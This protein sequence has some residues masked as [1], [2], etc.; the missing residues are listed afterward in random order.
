ML[1]QQHI[2]A[3]YLSAFANNYLPGKDDDSHTNLSWNPITA[4]LTTRETED[5]VY[6]CLDYNTFSLFWRKKNRLISKL[7]L[8][9][10]KHKD[11]MRWFKIITLDNNLPELKYEFK[12]ELPYEPITD[13]FRFEL[14]SQEDLNK[15]INILNSAQ[16]VFEQFLT[17]N[18]LSSEIRVWPH[19]FDMGIYTKVSGDLH[20]GIGL[21]IPD[22]MVD[23]FYYYVF[24]WKNGEQVNTS[25]KDMLENGRWISSKW[26][27]AVLE[28]HPKQEINEV[29]K[30][31]ITA[32]NAY[33][34]N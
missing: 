18:N 6:M 20:L 1:R 11:V 17:E 10:S 3:Q 19:H 29:K 33:L 23:G 2:A 25:D 7:D 15:N 34:N 32:K 26:N 8:H 14:I 9:G 28:Y 4:Q 30:F 16:Q 13:E 24:G 31:L 22:D 12:Y 21:A 5:G 27:G